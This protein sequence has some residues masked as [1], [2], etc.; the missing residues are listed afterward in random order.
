MALCPAK[1]SGARNRILSAVW[2]TVMISIFG[3]Q[4]L[5]ASHDAQQFSAAVV[6]E[7]RIH[8]LE[9]QTVFETRLE[10]SGTL[11]ITAY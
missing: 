9:L 1:G 4:L 6:L 2:P 7:S 5:N 11:T 8:N 3:H 10:N